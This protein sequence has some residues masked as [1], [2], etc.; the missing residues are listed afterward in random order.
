[1]KIQVHS[2]FQLRPIQ[3]SIYRLD[4]SNQVVRIPCQACLHCFLPLEPFT[5]FFDIS[6]SIPGQLIELQVLPFTVTHRHSLSL[7]SSSTRRGTGQTA[8]FSPQPLN[9]TKNKHH[10]APLLLPSHLSSD[11]PSPTYSVEHPT[12]QLH[13]LPHFGISSPRPEHTKLYLPLPSSRP[14]PVHHKIEFCE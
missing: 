10:I 13:P 4:L 9:I 14:S 11:R 6:P 12:A 2:C 7:L 3:V 5:P 8:N 1:M